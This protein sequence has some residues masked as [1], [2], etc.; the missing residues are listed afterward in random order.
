MK[1]IAEILTNDVRSVAIAGHVNPD[2]DC[3][4]SCMALALYLQKNAPETAVRVYLEEVRQELKFL[5]DPSVD[6]RQTADEDGA[7]PDLFV[8]LDA[9]ARERIGVAGDLFDR[10]PKTAC[11]DH[12]IGG[13]I[14]GINHVLPEV[15]SCCE[16]L[17][18]LLDRSLLD[19]KI[20]EALYTGIIH[21]TGVFQYSNTRPRTHEIAADLLSFGV[22]FSRIIYDSFNA[23]SFRSARFMGHCLDKSLL[24]AGGRIIASGATADDM[25]GYGVTKKEVGEVVT[26]L[27]LTEETDAAVF[28]YES[29]PGLFKVSLRSGAR[30]DVTRTAAVFGGGGHAKAAG[31]TVRGTLESVIRK[32]T[33]EL[34][35][36]LPRE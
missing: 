27:R 15:G 31:C 7:I 18:E 21:D 13:G 8:V 34:S 19:G 28:V 3:V 30:V 12:H 4:G 1:T 20:A 25:R 6:I 10:S 36:D 17:Y 5:L 23:R 22:D 32:V 29:E 2:G 24:F 9:S 35:R 11:I 33:D 26:Q 16:V 14:A